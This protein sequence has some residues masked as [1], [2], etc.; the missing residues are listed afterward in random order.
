MKSRLAICI[1]SAAARRLPAAAL[2]LLA[3][4]L[5]ATPQQ[6]TPHPATPPQTPQLY[7]FTHP[8]MGTTYALYLYSPTRAAAIAEA[9]RAFAVV[10]DLDNLLSNYRPQ[11]ELSRIN[12]NAWPGPVTT[13]PET[14]R[15]LR[16]SLE[17]S[18]RSQGAFDITVGALMK[19]WGFFRANGHLPTPAELNAVRARTGWQHVHLD[20]ARRTVRFDV[21][22]LELDPGGIG[23]G[24]AIDRM[25]QLLRADG[26]HSALLSAGSST[27]YALGAPP[28][29]FGWRIDVP[30]PLH[31]DKLVSTVDLRDT[32]LST[33]NCSEKHFIR[34]GHLYC[35]IMDPRTLH[36][37]EGRLQATI[38]APSA[39]DSDALSNVLFVDRA[40]ARSAVMAALPSADRA[41][42]LS[43]DQGTAETCSAYRWSAPTSIPCHP[44]ATPTQRPTP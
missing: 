14:L 29:R 36:P 15:F 21:P 32:S 9:D 24:F 38:I 17:W 20:L 31:P 43:G 3:C 4:T 2:A 7:S 22:G 30:D 26:F 6:P 12:R 37:V 1:N 42:V 25:Q 23:K 40:P 35:H 39:T 13:D 44:P 11:S 16:D 33:A 34:S 10:D 5:P 19:T 28:G 8:A 27:I 18:R 41:L